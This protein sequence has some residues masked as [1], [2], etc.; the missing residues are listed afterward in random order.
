[1]EILVTV[2]GDSVMPFKRTFATGINHFKCILQFVDKLSGKSS[3]LH[4]FLGLEALMAGNV[5]PIPAGGHFCLICTKVIKG[6]YA[7]ARYH[8]RDL[9]W[10][11][12]PSYT[13]PAPECQREYTSKAAFKM[14]RN[15]R[16]P[17]WRGVP[18]DTF[19]TP[20]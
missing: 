19:M 15:R 16:H 13:C 7:T 11:E 10:S 9:H 1:M 2:V 17:D 20:R 4:T 3:C 14:H 8:F 18:L 12:A 5:R 6:S